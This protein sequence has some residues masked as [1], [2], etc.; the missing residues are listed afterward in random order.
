MFTDF[1]MFYYT[2]RF[3]RGQAIWLC[4]SEY[5]TPAMYL[6]KFYAKLYTERLLYISKWKSVACMAARGTFIERIYYLV[7]TL[8]QGGEIR[9]RVLCDILL[10][11]L[12]ISLYYFDI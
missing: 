3:I 8:V 5:I 11:Q 12:E 10:V 9:P 4:R 2:V 1:V 6:C 7:W